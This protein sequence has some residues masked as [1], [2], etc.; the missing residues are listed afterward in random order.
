[1]TRA[2]AITACLLA[3][4]A[5]GGRSAAPGAQAE[6]PVQAECRD[7]ARQ[8]PDRRDF[9]RRMVIGQVNQQDRIEAE[10]REAEARAYADCLRRRGVLRG[11]GVEAVRRPAGF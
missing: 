11:G 1:M 3:L 6:S 5:C 2:L 8:S 9:Y 10:I 4:A 7:E